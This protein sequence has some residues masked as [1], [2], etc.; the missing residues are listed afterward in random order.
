[1]RVNLHSAHRLGVFI[2]ALETRDLRT[3]VAEVTWN[4]EL[5]DIYL[6]SFSAASWFLDG[7]NNRLA[8]RVLMDPNVDLKLC[9]VRVIPIQRH[10]S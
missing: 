9:R 10:K 6:V 2:T 1:M 7:H 5:Y 4:G 3:K 8:S